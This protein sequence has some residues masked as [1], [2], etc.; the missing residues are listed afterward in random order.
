ML[1]QKSRALK[2]VLIM[3]VIASILFCAIFTAGAAGNNELNRSFILSDGRGCF[4]DVRY[5]DSKYQIL[6]I[7]S[8]GST[9][10]I[11]QDSLCPYYASVCGRKLI[12]ASNNNIN[13]LVMIYD[14]ING[15]VQSVMLPRLSAKP[16]CIC[17]DDSLNCY[18]PDS[19]HPQLVQIYNK[20][21]KLISTTDTGSNVQMMFYDSGHTFAQNSRGAVDLTENKEVGGAVLHGAAEQ[22]GS[23]FCDSQGCVYKFSADTGFSM[24]RSCP[25]SLVCCTGNDLYTA[26]GSNIYK[27]SPENEIVSFYN[28]GVPVE[29]I[30]A[31]GRNVAFV[32]SGRL[33]ILSSGSLTPMPKPQ[34][35]SA[36]SQ[37]SRPG[38]SP[39]Q[40]SSSAP[41]YH[42]RS[43]T[44]TIS[45]DLIITDKQGTTFAGF[46]NGI[47]HGDYT[48][49][50]LDHNGNTLTSGTPGT[51]AKL[52]FTGGGKAL[53]YTIIIKG[54]VTGEGN[55]NSRDYNL[56]S[57]YLTDISQPDKYTAIAADV[58]ND[59]KLTTEDFYLI[60]C[61]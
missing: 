16:G 29:R 19:S 44:F 43:S 34:Q 27:L 14:L 32:S 42:I 50:A 23:I 51:G 49:S 13:E 12:I 11:A 48:V 2:P 53:T 58:N 30:I 21:G 47:D 54:D 39:S 5:N 55:V 18:I 15:A 40:Q 33:C 60:Y 37:S 8:D 36:P 52:I 4:V 57:E 38:S 28:A 7:R 61:Q 26:Q 10:I 45:G 17:I 25:Y 31:S 9:D 3:L 20:K 46:K 6:S 41:V 59:N 35:S 56:L 24:I 1:S 22:N